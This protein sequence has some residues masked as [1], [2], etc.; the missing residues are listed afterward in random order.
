MTNY[1]FLKSVV[2]GTITDDVKAKAAELLEKEEARLAKAAEKKAEKA[3]ADDEMIE[4]ILGILT[5][6]PQTAS[7]IFAALGEEV[8]PSAQKVSSLFTYLSALSVAS[9]L[10][11]FSVTVSTVLFGAVCAVIAACSATFAIS[12]LIFLSRKINRKRYIATSS[13]I[14]YRQF[15]IKIKFFALFLEKLLTN[16]IKVIILLI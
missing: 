3:A 15:F 4:A 7:D 10:F 1:D 2:D 11:D 13:Y 9:V 16:E 8:I 5:E 14:I 6:E 12:I